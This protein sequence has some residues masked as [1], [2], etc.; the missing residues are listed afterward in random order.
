MTAPMLIRR[1]PVL[2]I[3]GLEHRLRDPERDDEFRVDGRSAAN[4]LPRQFSLPF[5]AQAA[6]ARTTLLTVLGTIASPPPIQKE[7]GRFM[8]SAAGPERGLWSFMT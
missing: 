8:M 6:A 7:L 2:E 1:A 5:L 3:E 4:H